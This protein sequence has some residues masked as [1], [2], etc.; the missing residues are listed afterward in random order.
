M[1]S[2]QKAGKSPA[3]IK[4]ADPK[5]WIIDQQWL[6]LTSGRGKLQNIVFRKSVLA[7]GTLVLRR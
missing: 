4:R 5:F 6:T 2:A 1:S 3:L 7:A